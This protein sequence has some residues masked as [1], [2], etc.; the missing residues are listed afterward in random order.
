MNITRVP[1][2][3]ITSH[4]SCSTFAQVSVILLVALLCYWYSLFSFWQNYPR[5]RWD[6]P[7][8]F[9][10]ATVRCL[11]FLL[12]HRLNKK[13]CALRRP[14]PSFVFFLFLFY[15]LII[16]QSASV[17]Q[18]FFIIFIQIFSLVATFASSRVSINYPLAVH[19]SSEKETHATIH[20]AAANR[21]WYLTGAVLRILQC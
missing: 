12:A 16:T 7:T 13:L 2:F 18:L 4:G 19:A 9:L 10:T 5:L 21:L 8:D 15:I 14:I 17:W 1:G 6:L 3:K 11:L 20:S